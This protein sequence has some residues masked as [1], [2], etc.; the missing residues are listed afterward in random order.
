MFLIEVKQGH[1]AIKTNNPNTSKESPG[2]LKHYHDYESF[3]KDQEAVSFTKRDMLEVLR[4]KTEL[5]LVFGLNNLFKKEAGGK[6]STKGIKI[7]DDVEFVFLLANYLHFSDQ[8]QNELKHIKEGSKFFC[9]S[10]MGYGLYQRY[11]VRKHT[12]DNYPSIFIAE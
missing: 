10:F 8:L 11:I 5:G 3:C 9:S 7:E 12:I 4:Q 6:L 1:N 2:L